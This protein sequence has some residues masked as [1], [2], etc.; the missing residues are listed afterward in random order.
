M[1][2][3]YAENLN[4]NQGKLVLVGVSEPVYHQL[5]KTGLLD[6]LGKENI[7]KASSILGD[8]A[9]NAIKDA[10]AWLGQGDI[11]SDSQDRNDA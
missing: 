11:E 7:Y 1:I 2:T 5:D 6:Q 9:L 4:A 3:R 8:S 10:D